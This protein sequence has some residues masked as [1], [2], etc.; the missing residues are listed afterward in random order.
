M[1]GLHRMHGAH[2]ERLL[3]LV[4]KVSCKQELRKFAPLLRSHLAHQIKK[5]IH[6]QGPTFSRSRF[7][8]RGDFLIKIGLDLLSQLQPGLVLGVGISVHQHSCSGVAGIALDRL[9]VAAG[10]QELVSRAGMPQPMEHDLLELRGCAR[11]WRYH[12]VSSSG[13]MGRPSGSDLPQISGI[14]AQDLIR[15]YKKLNLLSC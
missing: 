9:E 11:H 8:R 2:G 13:A 15:G 5:A 10:L 7:C 3:H 1:H 4:K 12:L 14:H 6:G